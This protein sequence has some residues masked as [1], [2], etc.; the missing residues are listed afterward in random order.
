MFEATTTAHTAKALRLAHVERAQ[1][2]RG[3]V[4]VLIRGRALRYFPLGRAAL[5]GLSR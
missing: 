2:L 1:M 4:R 5:T 3:F